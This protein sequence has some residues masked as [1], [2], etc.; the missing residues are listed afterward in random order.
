VFGNL[1]PDSDAIRRR[2]A[3]RMQARGTDAYSL[4]MAVGRDCVGALQFLPDGE[5][6][7]PAGAI[8]GKL[9]SDADIGA[10]LDNLTTAPLGLGDDQDFRISIAGAQEESALLSLVMADILDYLAEHN[11]DPKPFVWTKTTDARLSKAERAQAARNYAKAG[12][13]ALGIEH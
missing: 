5:E 6:P 11:V 9:V 1:L 12:N 13:Q 7:D 8:T 10:M 2:V 4:L 3:E